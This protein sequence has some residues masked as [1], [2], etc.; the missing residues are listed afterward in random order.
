MPN[1]VSSLLSSLSDEFCL[2][3]FE[4]YLQNPDV[5]QSKTRELIDARAQPLKNFLRGLNAYLGAEAVLGATTVVGLLLRLE[6]EI[7][8]SN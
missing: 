3:T 1:N 6:E 8:Q 7:V 2:R 4:E 5:F